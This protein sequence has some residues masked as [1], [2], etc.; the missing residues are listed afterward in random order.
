MRE[1]D[2]PA[3]MVIERRS[4]PNPWPESAYYYELRFG[5]DSRFYTLQFCTPEEEPNRTGWWSWLRG[6]L[7]PEKPSTILGYVGLRLHNRQVHISTIA[8]DP[9]WQ[10]R[11]LGKLLLLQALEKATQYGAQRVTLEVRPS[12]H[13]AWSLYTTLG[14]VKTGVHPGYYRDGE[15]AWLMALDP[16]DEVRIAQLRSLEQQAQKRLVY[17]WDMSKRGEM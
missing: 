1:D 9:D 10:G 15:D 13:T 12:N 6:L 8:I 11:G 3:V 2:I 16:L 14:F 5:R 4:F 17:E 7:Q